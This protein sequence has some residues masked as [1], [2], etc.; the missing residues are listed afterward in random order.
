MTK[1]GNRY[2]VIAYVNED[3]FVNIENIRGLATRSCF[4]ANVLEEIF[5][6]DKETKEGEEAGAC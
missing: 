3:A 1:I 2:Q 6:N 4:V 5:G